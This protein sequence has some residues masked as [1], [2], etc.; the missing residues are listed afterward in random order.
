ME[1]L[2]KKARFRIHTFKQTFCFMGARFFK[3]KSQQ[4]IT[5]KMLFHAVVLQT[6][7]LSRLY[8]YNLW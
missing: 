6:A 8:V 4:T 1:L 3:K 7:S 2:W 5:P